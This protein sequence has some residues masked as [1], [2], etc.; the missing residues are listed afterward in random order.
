MRFKEIRERQRQ[1]EDNLV[2]TDGSLKDHNT[3][4][5]ALKRGIIGEAQEAL[6]ALHEHGEDSEEFRQEIVDILVFFATLLNH[7][8]MDEEEIHERSGR[9]IRK[10][11]L[12]YHPRNF[13]GRT[14]AEGMQYSKDIFNED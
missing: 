11:F 8:N 10:N 13:E 1:F 4:E 6:E 12:K 2:G 5:H 9:I 3:P 14:V 7:L